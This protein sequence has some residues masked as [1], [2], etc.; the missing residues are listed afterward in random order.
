M[1]ALLEPYAHEAVVVL[2]QGSDARAPG[3]AITAA[4]CG[5]WDHEPPCPL[6]PHH[7]AVEQLG[8]ETQLRIVFA[9]R[10]EDEAEVRRRIE[11]ALADGVLVGPDGVTTHWRLLHSAAGVI[12]TDEAPL[13]QQLRGT[14]L[15]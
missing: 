14:G 11:A 5:S 10:P 7:T 9:S 3:G 2:E 1:T 15:T 4:L 13:A 6:A 12:R 8:A